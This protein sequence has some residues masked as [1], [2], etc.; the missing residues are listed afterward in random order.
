M[1]YIIILI[2]LLFA[3]AAY[4][5]T[6]LA[7]PHNSYVL[8]TSGKLSSAEITK[9]NEKI[10]HLNSSTRNEYGILLLDSLND[11]SIEDVAYATFNSWGVGKKD[12]DNGILIVVA[13]KERKSRIETG[14]GVGG[15]LPDILVSDILRQN[16]SPHLK[17]DQF[18]NGF[19]S[20]LDAI[21]SKLE[22]RT[23]DKKPASGCHIATV[24]MTALTT[25]DLFIGSMLFIVILFLF[26]RGR[27]R[28]NKINKM[29][30]NS[31][32]DMEER[33]R[34]SDLKRTNSN[35]Y[36]K[37]IS[38]KA[39]LESEVNKTYIQKPAVTITKTVTTTNYTFIK[40]PPF[41]PSS[42]SHKRETAD[43]YNL[44]TNPGRLHKS[45]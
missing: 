28:T 22:A 8:D 4:A 2:T 27:G 36:L 37:K 33:H 40:P 34:I 29:I 26:V 43:S 32:L 15:E 19:N 13:V 7:A 11:E 1:K 25:L 45:E 20:T 18:Y 39:F 35:S 42:P 12:L 30:R 21:S 5:Y 17:N 41:R 16:L 24:N 6:P 23:I 14:K 31:K 3:S 9:L 10:F 38:H 44:R